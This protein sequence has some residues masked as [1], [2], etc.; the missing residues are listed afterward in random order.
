MSF[1]YLTPV[2]G[3]IP[4]HLLEIIIANRLEYLNAIFENKP[5]GFNEYMIEGS[6]YDNV[7]HFMLCVMNHICKSTNLKQFICT[8]ENKLFMRRVEALSSYDLRCLAKQI[9]RCIRK[10]DNLPLHIKS[11]EILCR[12]LMLKELAQH[13]NTPSHNTKCLQH[14]IY[15]NFKFCL[16]FVANREVEI[17]NGI[18]TITCGRWIEFFKQIFD[19]NL[20]VKLDLQKMNTLRSDPRIVDLVTRLLNGKFPLETK[21]FEAHTLV[22]S[23]VN[24]EMKYFPPCMM[25][26]H[27]ILRKKHRLSHDQRFIYSL[28][29]KDIGM[30]V[31]EAITFWSEEY[32]QTP[33]GNHTCCHSW[34]KDEKKYLYGIRHL[35]GLEGGRKN[36][37]SVN[38][39][40]IQGTLNA[41]SEGGCPF[42]TFDEVNMAKLLHFDNKKSHLID[43]NNLIN[44]KMYTLACKT[45][46]E[47]RFTK[48]TNSNCEISSFNFNPVIYYEKASKTK[49]SDET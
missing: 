26:L 4:I 15:M 5:T 1:Y 28:F 32:K 13:I 41:C 35:Y 44:K 17:K 42:K 14:N 46:L 45:Y 49:L 29:L 11:L 37:T 39:S 10:H 48:K 31:E 3:E 25:N 8:S 9:L 33:C 2:K 19:T 34:E 20:R 22:S 12:H 40:R 38:C 36:Y 18:A 16:P 24:N 43:I 27:M 47:A 6:V 7:G 21:Y 30:P 23:S